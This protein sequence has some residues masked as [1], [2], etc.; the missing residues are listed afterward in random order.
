MYSTSRVCICIIRLVWHMNTPRIIH[1]TR[2]V[3]CIQAN[4]L[5]NNSNT[6]LYIVKKYIVRARS[7]PNSVT[8]VLLLASTNILASTHRARSTFTFY[9]APQL[10][11]LSQFIRCIL[12]QFIRPYK[13]ILQ[14]SKLTITIFYQSR[15]HN[16]RGQRILR[17]SSVQGC[18]L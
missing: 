4:R 14:S 9:E 6:S 7:L 1:R 13:V 18:V 8:A 3:A 2:T 17:R 16:Q 5:T 11:I 12:S 15:I 10:R